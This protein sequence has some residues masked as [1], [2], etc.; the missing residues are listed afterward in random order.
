[1]NLIAIHLP[2]LRERR[3]DIPLLANYFL[4]NIGA[5]Y[6]RRNLAISQAALWWLQGL[7]WPGN[8]RQLKQWIERTLLV[9]GKDV[10]EVEDFA[11]V[12]EM[13]LPQFRKE[14]LP[15]AGSM[16]LEQIEKAM[17]LKCLEQYAGNI[18]KVAE[19]L[20]LSRQALY[21]R[22]EKYGIVP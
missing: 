8:I 12:G 3:D 9:S 22:F 10:L 14:A 15:A 17:I 2:P 13:D 1:L 20:G 16:T 19:A 5:V 4:E 21:R 11:A 7:E 18:S 6:R